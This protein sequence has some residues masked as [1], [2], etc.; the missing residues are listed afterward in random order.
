MVLALLPKPASA[1]PS[2]LDGNIINISSASSGLMVMLSSG[3]PDN[4]AG[5]GYGW[6]LIPEAK[7]TMIA[8]ALTTW[9]T[10]NKYVVVYTNP[11]SG[12][13]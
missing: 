6:M 11:L 13:N 10:G 9:A 3:V 7:K 1:S 12:G 5:V 2:W 4:C 8:T